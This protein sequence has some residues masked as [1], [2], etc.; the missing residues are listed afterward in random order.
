VIPA[1]AGALRG[2]IGTDDPGMPRRAQ[3]GGQRE[4]PG[5]RAERRTIASA[6]LRE[7]ALAD[8]S[9][10]AEQLCELLY[11]AARLSAARM[12]VRR[13]H[14]QAG[15]DQ[16]RRGGFVLGSHYHLPD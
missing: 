15:F 12:R 1:R 3:R 5:S 9:M 14:D 10:S 11:P 6:V 13:A 16:V 7:F 8:E 2:W 4:D